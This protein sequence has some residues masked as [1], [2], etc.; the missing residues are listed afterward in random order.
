MFVEKAR[1][2]RQSAKNNRDLAWD[3][4]WVKEFHTIANALYAATVLNTIPVIRPAWICIRDGINA[5][6][7][8]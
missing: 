8:L 6:F 7:T 2:T 3:A 4:A 1:R 5:E